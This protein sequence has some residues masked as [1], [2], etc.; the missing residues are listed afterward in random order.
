VLVGD[1]VLVGDARGVLV[2]DAMLQAF[3]ALTYGDASPTMIIVLDDDTD[4]LGY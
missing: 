3:N 1:G 4:Y 2:G